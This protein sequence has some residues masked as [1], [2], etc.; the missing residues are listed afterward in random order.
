MRALTKTF[1]ILLLLGSSFTAFA[2]DST[3]TARRASTNPWTGTNMIIGFTGRTGNSQELNFS[4]KLRIKHKKNQWAKILKLEGEANTSDGKLSSGDAYTFG[5][6]QRFFSDN[7][8]RLYTSIEGKFD[9]FGPYEYQTAL[10]AGYGRD[11][12][13]LESF[14]WDIELGPGIM[15][16]RINSE[17]AKVENQPIIDLQ[18][19]IDW[20]ITKTFIF[21]EDF[22]SDIGPKNTYTRSVTSFKNTIKGPLGWQISFKLEHN[23]KFPPGSSNTKHL[24]F[25]TE[26]GLL[27]NF[28]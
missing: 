28:A 15:Q 25:T 6:L 11:I 9:K 4:G 1:G 7:S 16:S 8:Q 5:K 13:K 27:Y 19:N 2:A 12:I 22:S 17:P 10:A 24:D 26:L 20:Y 21:E 14:V 23:T 18:S 3:D